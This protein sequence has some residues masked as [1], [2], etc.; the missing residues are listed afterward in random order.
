MAWSSFFGGKRTKYG[1]QKVKCDGQV[2][3]SK[4]EY[5]RYLFLKRAEEDGLIENLQC[6]VQFE[7]EPA[8]IEEYEE[9]LKTK[10]VTRTRVAQRAM[11]YTCDFRY[12][13]DGVD[14]IEDVKGSAAQAKRD[15][16]YQLRKK[17]LFARFRIRVK[18]V[19]K[20]N[21]EI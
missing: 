17:L 2:F 10:T 7:L 8:V 12:T 1:N 16:A 4:K 21:E 6:Q 14:V 11:H 13:K 15:T 5:Q 20:S 3:D 19:Y 9:Q 18:E